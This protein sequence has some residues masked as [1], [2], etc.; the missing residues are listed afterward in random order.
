MFD[1]S[2]LCRREDGPSRLT[3]TAKCEHGEASQHEGPGR[4][5]RDCGSDD[6]VP[7]RHGVGIDGRRVGKE[8][9]NVRFPQKAGTATCL[10]AIIVSALESTVLKKQ[11]AGGAPEI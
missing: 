1:A 2:R 10:C 3:I 7:D 5:L 11:L 4:G 6:L 8:Y 9:R